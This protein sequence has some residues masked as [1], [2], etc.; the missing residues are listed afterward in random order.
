MKKATFVLAPSLAL[1]MVFGA[2]SIS[3]QENS[4]TIEP[5]DTLSK[6][7]S[8]HEGVTVE[9]INE[10]NPELDPLNLQIG[11]EVKIS[12]STNNDQNNSTREI[13]HTVEPGET[14]QSIAN[15]H[16]DLTLEQFKALN[17][18]LEEGNLEVGS[19]VKVR[20]TTEDQ[21]EEKARSE[22]IYHTIQSG[23]TLANTAQYYEGVTLEQ[24]YELNPGIDPRYLTVGDEIQI[25]PADHEQDSTSSENAYHTIEA[26]DTLQEIADQY[27]G[28]T[29]EDIRNLNPE[30]DPRSLNIG[31]EVRVR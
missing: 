15:L 6:I 21:N 11:T 29:L 17:P 12:A 3:A 10:L 4:V 22:K 20:E 18:E 8:E 19:E 28:V 1:G 14:M 13:Y 5:G 25:R 2:G 31:S 23:N 30:I 26:G 27:E 9:E 16:K 7:A 24:I